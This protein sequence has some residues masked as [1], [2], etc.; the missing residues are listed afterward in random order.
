VAGEDLSTPISL[1]LQGFSENQD[2]KK[3]TPSYSITKSITLK[4][5]KT[6]FIEKIQ[7]LDAN[8]KTVA[9]EDSW[10]GR[11]IKCFKD[12]SCGSGCFN[13]VMGCPKTSW[14]AFLACLAGQCGSCVAKCVA[15]ATCDCTW[16]CKWAA[17]CCE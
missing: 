7:E 6:D 1:M 9:Y 8:S 15:C 14:A 2:P 3:D 10:W 12:G 13:A 11:I 17:G 16:W 5:N 4:T